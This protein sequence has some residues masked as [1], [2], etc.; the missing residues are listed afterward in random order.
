LQVTNVFDEYGWL[1]SNSGGFT[2]SP[3]RT[4]VAQL[5]FDI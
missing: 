1:V 3:G 4:Y 2:Y 5:A